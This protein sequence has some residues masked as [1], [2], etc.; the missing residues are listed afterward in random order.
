MKVDA[1]E[2]E[3]RAVWDELDELTTAA[4]GHGERLGPVRLRR[5]G[6]LYREVAADLA[7][8]RRRF[9]G[10]PMTARLERRV[11][12]ARHLVYAAPTRR[13]SVRAFFARDYWRLVADAWVA[14][15]VAA[16]LLF[17]PS[18]AGGAWAIEDPGAAAGVVPEAFRPA[19]ESERDWADLTAGE[20]ATFTTSV[21]TNNIR[22]T[23]LAFAGGV[24]FAIPTALVLLYNGLI[25][26][27]VGGLM[28][29]AGN[30]A[31]FVELVTA[32]G[33]LELSC[34]VVAGA[35]GLRLGW[36]IVEPGRRTRGDA[37]VAEA[38]RSVAIALG[39][40]PWLVIA[41]IIEGNRARLADLG[42]PVVVGVGL[43]FGLLFWVLVVLRGRAPVH[44][45]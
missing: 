16:V 28:V 9:A 45:D 15:L 21:F 1:F 2:A 40:A 30:G 8:A 19:A 25:L 24:V 41:G 37:A 23:L 43:V 6:T 22:V 20:Q 18:V 7:L 31:G 27:T 17:A 34:I 12:R 39:T 14:L 44:E 33:V 5:L 35:A 36:A 11:V 4:R 42:I 29:G 32:H 38:R 13:G 26:G 3:R 10:D